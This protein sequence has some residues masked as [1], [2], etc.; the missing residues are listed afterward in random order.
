MN[1]LLRNILALPEQASTFAR[2]V[3]H[4]HFF[5]ISVTMFGATAVG[6]T[7][8]YFVFRYRRTEPVSPTEPIKPPIAFESLWIA[9][10]LGLF[11]LFWVIGYRLYVRMTLPP[12]NSIDVY[13]TA[14][15]WMW[16]FAYA[17]GR[18]S[19]A[20]L[21]APSKRPVRLNMISRDVIHSL[22]I[23]AFRIKQD[24]LP[25]RYTSTWFEAIAPGTHQILCAEYCG[26]EHSKMWGSVVV[27]SPTD[28]E[29]WL[30]GAS[31]P[32]LQAAVQLT[33]ARGRDGSVYGEPLLERGIAS[34]NA[35]PMSILGREVATRHACFGCH[36][37]DGRE[38]IGPTWRGLYGSRRPL[39]DGTDTIADAAYLTESMM[40][41]SAKIVAGFA[42]RMPSF[43]GLLS[44]PET[45][46]LLELIKSMKDGEPSGAFPG[47][48]I[49]NLMAPSSGVTGE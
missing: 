31:P 41:P 3:D 47:Q 11:I 44:P 39:A 14:Q 27:L 43:R 35:R 38:H 23:P 46:A 37:L 9:V 10:L 2:D 45:A 22:S 8:I 28:Y 30:R 15:Q 36:T 17:D 32:A 24:V 19:I 4:L 29:A 18:G 40:D 49:E 13:V 48:P 16:K 26:V 1:E 7:A 25:G 20:V 42:P 34:G 33:A 12:E 21:I 5:V 6:G